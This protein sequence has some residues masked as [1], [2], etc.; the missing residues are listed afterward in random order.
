MFMCLIQGVLLQY[1]KFNWTK[2]IE[3]PGSDLAIFKIKYFLN[4]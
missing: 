3:D 4:I 2:Y 1:L